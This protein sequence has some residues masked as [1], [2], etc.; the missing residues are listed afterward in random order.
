MA[1]TLPSPSTSVEIEPSPPDK[2]TPTWPIASRPQ[3]TLGPSPPHVSNMPYTH[4]PS[5]TIYP[6]G[7]VQFA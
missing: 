6:G 5:S 3:F 2:V 7:W 4:T 1:T